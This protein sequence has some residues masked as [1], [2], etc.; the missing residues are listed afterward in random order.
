MFVSGVAIYCR[1]LFSRLDYGS[2]TLRPVIL[3]RP[4]VG[5]DQTCVQP[6]RSFTSG[7]P[8]V[9]HPPRRRIS[10]QCQL[11]TLHWQGFHLL[12]HQSPSLLS[13]RTDFLGTDLRIRNSF[14]PRYSVQ[15]VA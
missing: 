2:L 13:R 14:S 10:L 9:G 8:T 12:D 4:P 6:S 7:L 15:I 5:A 3:A 11:G 1:A